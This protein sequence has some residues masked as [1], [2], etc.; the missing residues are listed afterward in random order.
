[1]QV[2]TPPVDTATANGFLGGSEI[3]FPDIAS[4]GG[5]ELVGWAVTGLGASGNA[6]VQTY[7]G[8]TAVATPQTLGSAVG[9]PSVALSAGGPGLGVFQ[10]ADGKEVD[11]AVRP[12]GGTFSS[13]P[14]ATSASPGS[15]ALDDAGDGVAVFAPTGSGAT[16][17]MARGFDATPP[18][19]QTASISGAARIGQAAAFAASAT[20]FWGP[21]SFAWNFGDGS[22]ATSASVSHVFTS[23]G[24]RSVTLT[25]TDAVG[26]AVS[27]SG[28]VV[29]SGITPVLSKVSET[30]S[31]FRV[32][33]PTAVSGR[34]SKHKRKPPTGTTFSFT[35]NEAASVAFAFMHGAPGRRSGGHCVK[36]SK[37]LRSHGPCTRVVSNGTIRRREVAGASR[38]AFSGR[39]GHRALAPGS[40]AVTLAPTA[41]GVAGRPHTLKFKI[42]R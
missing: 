23:V 28:R 30:H 12:S 31:S 41:F 18:A 14:L 26:N 32:G 16:G 15:V 27:R 36:P 21:V 40:Y 1:M 2:V 29:L 35:L 10:N 6:R 37:R 13:V 17:A 34:A 19:I 33:S 42:V 39:I 38:L 22:R 11:A 20:D 24:S 25:A 3:N 4:A 9:G 8:S 7:K 5:S